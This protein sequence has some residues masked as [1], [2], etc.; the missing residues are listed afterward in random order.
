MAMIVPISHY[1]MCV[2][3]VLKSEKKNVSESPPPPV[4]RLFQGLRKMLWL[5]QQ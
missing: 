1:E 2:E 5:A 3:N 4:E